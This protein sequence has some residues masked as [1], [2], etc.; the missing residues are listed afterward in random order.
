MGVEA[1]QTPGDGDGAH[2]LIL[3]GDLVHLT[4]TDDSG[5]TWVSLAPRGAAA[6]DG[7]L[8]PRLGPPPIAARLIADG[9]PGAA[10]NAVQA[11]MVAGGILTAR[12]IRRREVSQ[13]V[14]GIVRRALRASVQ[15]VID[16]F[17]IESPQ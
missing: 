13:Q 15:T 3:T 17:V 7:H 1:D 12:D 2:R 9:W 14:D 11:A 5:A 6:E 4:W 16:A 10:A 8:Y